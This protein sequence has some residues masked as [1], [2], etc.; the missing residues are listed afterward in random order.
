MASCLNFAGKRELLAN[1]LYWSGISFLLSQLPARNLLLVLSYHRL[2]RAD[3]DRFD[4]SIFSATAEQFNDQIACLK[5]HA[6]L[7]TLEESLAFIDG[8]NKDESCRHRVLLTFDDGYLDN[9]EIAYPILRSHG[10]QGVFFL[11]T[12]MVGSCH[13]PWWDQIAYLLRT[14]QTRRFS[15]HYPGRLVVDIDKDGLNESLQAILKLYKRPDNL[16]AARFMRELVEESKGEQ[17][18]G[19]LRRFLNWDEAR[20]MA[21]GG[22]AIGSHTHT[23]QVLSQLVPERQRQELSLSRSIIMEKLGMEA[24]ALAY[25]VGHKSSFS[26]QTRIL[27]QESGYRCAFSHHGGTNIQGNIF[28]YDVKRMIVNNQSLRHFQVQT[29]VSRV[30]GKFWP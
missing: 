22:M 14:A 2:G 9:Y 8:T 23:H 25:P 6:S 29:A 19:T 24:K 20:E 30:T 5:Q 11:A 17:P 27:A 7:V 4:P 12:D 10:V 13:V 26:D 18:P 15:F 21:R 1:G 16:D 3:E 28:P